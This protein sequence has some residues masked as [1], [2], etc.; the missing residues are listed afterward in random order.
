MI[1]IIIHHSFNFFYTLL[2]TLLF[3]PMIGQPATDKKDKKG[4]GVMIV[5]FVTLRINYM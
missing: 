4:Q 3:H 2:H 5:N 1:Y